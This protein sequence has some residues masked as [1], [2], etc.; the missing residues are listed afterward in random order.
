MFLTK[1]EYQVDVFVL[2]SKKVVLKAAMEIVEDH[3]NVVIMGYG[4]S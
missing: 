4:R 3:Y 1:E 2:E